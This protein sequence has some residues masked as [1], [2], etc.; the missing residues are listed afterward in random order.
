MFDVF[1]VEAWHGKGVAVH[2]VLGGV[3]V[4]HPHLVA[5]GLVGETGLEVVHVGC[6]DVTHLIYRN[7]NFQFEKVV[8]I[9]P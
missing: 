6:E 4:P 9:S 1:Y 5:D 3:Q 7:S 8:Q 2:A